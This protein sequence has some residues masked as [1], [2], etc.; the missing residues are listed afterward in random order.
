MIELS[1]SKIS[2]LKIPLNICAGPD[3][4]VDG[5]NVQFYIN[6][7]R[8][9]FLT[10][11]GLYSTYGIPRCITGLFNGGVDHCDL[12]TDPSILLPSYEIRLATNYGPSGVM[13]ELGQCEGDHLVMTFESLTFASRF[14]SAPLRELGQ[15][16]CML[17]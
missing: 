17:S 12:D 7:V 15:K 4:I 1:A 11:W 10:G 16:I 6:G 9:P 5:K 14:D 8:L 3:T 2:T 13:R